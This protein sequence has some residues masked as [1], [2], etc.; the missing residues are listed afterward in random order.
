MNKPLMLIYSPIDVTG[1]Y[2]A[3]GR[4]LCKNLIELYKEKYN[5]KIAACSW[6]GL[7]EGFIQDNHNEW[8]FLEEYI[9]KE[10]LTKQPEVYIHHGIPNEFNKVGNY[11]ILFTA[12]IETTICSA[13]WLEGINKADLV[14]VPSQHAKNVFMNT[15]YDKQDNNTKQ[16]VGKL[17]CETKVEVIPEGVNIDIFKYIPSLSQESEIKTKLDEIPEQFCYLFF[18]SWLQGEP[19]EDRKNVGGLIKV[20]LETFKN[21]K[22]KPALILKTSIGSCSIPNKEKLL[23]KIDQIRQTVNSKDLPNIYLFHGEISEVEV[24]ELYNHPKVKAMVSLTRGEGYGKPLIEFTQSKK[25]LIVSGWSG[26][27]DYCNPEFTTLLPGALTPIHPSAQVKDMLIEGSSWFSVDLGHAGGVLKD[28]F[29]NY[30]KYQTQGK[31]LGFYCKENFNQ[32]KVKEKLYNVLESNIQLPYSIK[33][34]SLKLV[35]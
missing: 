8:G 32:E 28:C 5:I 35:K 26:H 33:L 9:L 20:F 19:T 2:P 22:V 6:G 12:G 23:N 25:P 30:P 24:N 13:L 7:P 29:E 3:Q 4:Q 15:V 1:G 10:N 31:R 11:S 17:K 27:L 14:I 21:K 16:I 18:G 34:P